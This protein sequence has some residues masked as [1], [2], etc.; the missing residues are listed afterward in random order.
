MAPKLDPKSR[1][2]KRQ[3]ML[4]SFAASAEVTSTAATATSSV[5]P[6]TRRLGSAPV[7]ASHCSMADG[8]SWSSSEWADRL[9]SS[10]T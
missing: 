3:P 8:S 1:R 9:S 5:T 7:A 6:S 4:F 10:R 2:A